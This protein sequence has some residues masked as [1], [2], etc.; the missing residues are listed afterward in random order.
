MLEKTKVE[1]IK[2]SREHPHY[3]M[4]FEQRLEGGEGGSQVDTRQREEQMPSPC[5]VFRNSLSPT[6]STV[7]S[8]L[9]LSHVEHPDHHGSV[10]ICLCIHP[11]E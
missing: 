2:I 1:E 7:L 6:E 4:S 8:P 9:F 11:G 10:V 5:G 3:K